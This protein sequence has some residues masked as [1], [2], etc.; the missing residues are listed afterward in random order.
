MIITAKFY[1]PDEAEA[2]AAALGMNREGIF[3]ISLDLPPVRSNN[4]VTTP[5]GFFTNMSVGGVTGIPLTMYAPPADRDIR[6]P[7]PSTSSVQVICRPGEAKRVAS[8][9]RS[10]GGHQ[11]RGG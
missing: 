4:A 9:L 6:E 7:R 11:V 8:L 1:T 5:I 10:K 3:D 2:A